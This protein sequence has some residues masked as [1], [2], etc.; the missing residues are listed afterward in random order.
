MKK[1]I[2]LLLCLGMFAAVCAGCGGPQITATGDEANN[3][4]ADAYKD[5]YDDLLN[6]LSAWGYINPLEKNKGVTYTEMRADLIGAK[7]GRRFN[8]Q[9]TK[10][11]TI[12]L[13]EFDLSKSNATADE[14]LSSVKADG[15]FKNLFGDK[16]DSVY[17]SSNGKYLMVY[18]DTSIKD[19]TKDTD[20]NYTKRQ[21]VIDKFKK[22]KK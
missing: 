21:E 16:V 19:D 1:I 13:Y 2:A 10:N 4:S 7:Q 22:F 15:S 8:A 9:H 14:V 12:E 17:L 11:A 20:E 5:T 6:Y 18:N 3:K